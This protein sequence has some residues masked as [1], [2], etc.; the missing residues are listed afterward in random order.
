MDYS[1]IND[2]NYCNKL[3]FTDFEDALSEYNLIQVVNFNTWSRLVGT[4]LRTSILD[5]NYIKD[6]TVLTGVIFFNPFFG[7]HVLIEFKVN[8]KKPLLTQ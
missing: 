4:V 2:D 6:P 5:N 3:L 1:W 7:D 8:A